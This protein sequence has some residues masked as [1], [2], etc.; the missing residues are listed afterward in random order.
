M[1]AIGDVKRRQPRE[2]RDE[3]IA[4]GPGD[5]PQRV[6]DAVRRGKIDERRRRDD[7]RGDG[8]DLGARL[9]DQ[10]HRSGLRVQRQHVAGAIVFLVAPRPFVLLDDVLVVFGEGKAGGQPHL[11]VRAHPQTI[12]VD[13]RLGLEHQRLLLQPAE[14][15][16][17]PRVDRVSVRIGLLRQLDLG[18]RHPQEAQRI[19]I[20]QR[21]RLVGIDDVVGDCG[22]AG[23]IGRI[24]T[25]RTEGMQSGHGW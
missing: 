13:A 12:E 6:R 1:V 2:R 14:V 18:S 22:D 5:P 9:V 23:R 8:V 4:I 3:R 16:F 17:G 25:Q 21:S 10:E 15:G 7:A 19:A 20:G 24:G 11:L